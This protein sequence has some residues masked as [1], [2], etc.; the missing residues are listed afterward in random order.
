[1]G[2]VRQT[3][4]YL[5][6]GQ[7][8]AKTVEREIGEGRCWTWHHC[9]RSAKETPAKV[10]PPTH[11]HLH[12]PLSADLRSMAKH[13]PVSSSFVFHSP[14]K[15]THCVLSVSLWL[16][17]ILS[18]H[19]SCPLL[20]LS[21]VPCGFYCVCFLIPVWSLFVTIYEKHRSNFLPIC[22]L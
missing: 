13:D 22:C 10:A 5:D 12:D 17:W 6:E 18:V 16:E 4:L 20:C 2:G 14:R 9:A 11:S 8:E 19:L 3:Y 15:S 7:W 1:M 21:N